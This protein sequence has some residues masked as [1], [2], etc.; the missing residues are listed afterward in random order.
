MEKKKKREKREGRDKREKRVKK[1]E[2]FYV[3]WLYLYGLCV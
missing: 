3:L 1:D 2:A